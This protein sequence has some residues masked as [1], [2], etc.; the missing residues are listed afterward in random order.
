MHK[1]L[2]Q[3]FDLHHT[4]SATHKAAIHA[5]VD[6]VMD[7]VHDAHAHVHAVRR[8]LRK[9]LL[10][11]HDHKN[12]ANLTYLKTRMASHAAAGDALL[13]ALDEFARTAVELED[14][15]TPATRVIAGLLGTPGEIVP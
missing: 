7:V 13:A 10:A 6:P 8:A 9:A 15:F 14:A 12:D 4:K 2:A 3:M 5:Q 1:E 11:P